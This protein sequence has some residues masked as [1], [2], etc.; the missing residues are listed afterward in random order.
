MIFQRFAALQWF[1]IAAAP[2]WLAYLLSLI[3]ITFVAAIVLTYIRP[4]LVMLLHAGD[5]YLASPC[6]S[7]L[8]FH[9]AATT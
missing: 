1:A 5:W 7:R 9:D 3:I 8:F 4:L 6:I 2:V